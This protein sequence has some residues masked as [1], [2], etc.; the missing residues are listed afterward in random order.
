MSKAPGVFALVTG[1]NWHDPAGGRIVDLRTSRE[2]GWPLRARDAEWTTH[3]LTTDPWVIYA[4]TWGEYATLEAA[5]IARAGAIELA[6]VREPIL[7]ARREVY[8]DAK[9]RLAAAQKLL[10]PLR[11]LPKSDPRREGANDVWFA[12]YL[13]HLEVQKAHLADFPLLVRSYLDQFKGATL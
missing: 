5:Q 11:R 7:Q 13:H 8:E 1:T 9:A 6:R 10:D 2:R 4:M 3:D 12:A